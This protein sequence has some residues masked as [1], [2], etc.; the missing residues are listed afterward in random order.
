MT[1]YIII[2]LLILLLNVFSNK[3]VN[4]TINYRVAFFILFLFAA[5]RGNGDGDYFQYL[6]YSKLIQSISDLFNSS[7]PMEIGFRLI[8]FIVNSLGLHEQAVI[9]IMNLI[10]LVCIYKFIKMYSPDKMFSII[11]FFPIFLLL[12]MHAART[13][14]ALGI[15]TLGFK[16]IYQGKFLKYVAVIFLASCFHQSVLVLTGMYFLRNIRINRLIGIGAIIYVIILSYLFSVN[17]LIQI[18]LQTL[19]FS[20]LQY[21][22]MIYTQSVDYGYSFKLYDPR[23]LL[24]TGIYIAGSFTLNKS[25]KLENMLMNYIWFNVILIILFR[26]NT[27]FVT[28]LT[29]YF[30]I[31]TIIVIPLILLRYKNHQFMKD[32]V[33]YK[34]LFLFLYLLYSGWL[35]WNNVDYKVFFSYV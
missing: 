1:P 8:S 23:L 29:S 20:S 9:A 26:E 22:F 32:Y 4:E 18:A 6:D 11:L 2:I 35:I 33:L 10:S 16:Y 31:Y 30:N 25:N 34:L 14:V 28:R 5:L 27:I 12:D 13:A 3:G 17:S 24:I 7:F 19:P 21:K 15:S